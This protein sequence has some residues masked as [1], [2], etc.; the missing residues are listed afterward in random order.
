ML[1]HAPSSAWFRS[2][3]PVLVA[4]FSL[5]A[6]ACG[7]YSL[8]PLEEQK[9]R[10]L[11]DHITLRPLTAETILEAWAEPTYSHSEPTQFFL[12]AGVNHIPRFAI[13]LGVAPLRRDDPI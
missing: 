3:L 9:A 12:V 13:P 2:A 5:S 1:K 4:W 10:I 7:L 11:S 6:G 8:P